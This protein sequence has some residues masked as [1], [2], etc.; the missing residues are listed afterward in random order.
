MGNN[1][2]ENENEDKNE[3]KDEDGKNMEMGHKKTS[4]D[5]TR[6]IPDALVNR[7]SQLFLD[8]FCQSLC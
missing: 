6:P 3:D 1:G 5:G 2:D 4:G 7:L 8:L